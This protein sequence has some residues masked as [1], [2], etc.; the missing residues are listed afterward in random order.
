MN[1]V[2]NVK[3]TNTECENWMI[4]VHKPGFWIRDDLMRTVFF[5]QLFQ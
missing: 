5:K 1:H 3:N 2:I 4:K